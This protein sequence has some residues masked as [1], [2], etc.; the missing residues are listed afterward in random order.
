MSPLSPAY[1]GEEPPAVLAERVSHHP[2][3]MFPFFRRWPYGVGRDLVYTFIWNAM[4]AA[5]FIV[6]AAVVSGKVPGPRYAAYTLVYANC[7]G[8]TIHL[9]FMLGSRT[10]ATWVRRHGRVVYT[11]Y[12]TVVSIIGVVIGFSL[13]STILEDSVTMPSVADPQWLISVVAISLMISVVLSIVFFWREK[14]VIAEAALERQARHAAQSE[15]EAMHANLRALQAQIEPHFLFNTLANVTSLIDREPARAKRMLESFIGFLR[16]SL[17]ATRATRTTLADEFALIASY[18]DTLQIRMGERLN[19]SLD[20]PGPLAS[21]SLP[22]MI[23]QPIV[24]NA[25]R[26][27]LEPK[28]EGGAISLRAIAREQRLVLEVADTGVGF[29]EFTRSGV[30]LA[31]IR[32]RLKLQYGDRARLSIR[33]NTPSGTIVSVEIPREQP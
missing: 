27:G 20:L 10:V 29:T 3:E 30:G 4:F 13:A 23:L 18:L 11:L 17:S 19:V 6:M 24:E 21:V 15:R 25:I 28:V 22:P 12:Y 5:F 9:L 2:L 26:H 8:Y 32:E 7:I 1:R 31:N 16:A 14:S 33:A